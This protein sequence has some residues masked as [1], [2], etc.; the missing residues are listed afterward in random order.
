MGISYHVLGQACPAGTSLTTLYTVPANT[1][2]VVSTIVINDVGNAGG[3]A[4]VSVAVN[5]AADSNAQYLYGS[6]TTGLIITPGNSF[7]ATLGGTLNAGDVVRGRSSAGNEFTFQL[8]G[9]EIS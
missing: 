6:M 2:T 5:G 7:S 4:A 9:S 3:S 1:Q 8:F